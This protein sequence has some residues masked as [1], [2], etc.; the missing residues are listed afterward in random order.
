MSN[1][2]DVSALSFAEL[3]ELMTLCETILNA[4][5]KEMRAQLEKDAKL[6]GLT[7]TDNGKPKAK[8]GPKPRKEPESRNEHDDQTLP[9]G[10]ADHT[11]E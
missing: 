6:I 10:P 8:R 9:L 5:R 2:P 4:K 3:K 7:L 1:I 11:R